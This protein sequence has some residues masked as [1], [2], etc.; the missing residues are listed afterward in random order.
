MENKKAKDH[1]RKVL[2]SDHL[3]CADLEDFIEEG[4]KLTFL[5]THVRQELNVSVAGKKGNFNIAYFKEPI[6]P[7]VLNSTNCKVMKTL[8]NGSPFVQDWVNVPV[9]LFIDHSVKM[10][11]EVVGGV[12]IKGGILTL[13]I[14]T[15]SMTATWNNAIKYYTDNGKFDAVEEKFILTDEVKEQIKKES[16]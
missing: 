15:K 4:V 13:P 8:S 11:G 16:L 14:L 10:K 12:R 9:E 3:G 5:I 7:L 1:Y 6:K 2:K